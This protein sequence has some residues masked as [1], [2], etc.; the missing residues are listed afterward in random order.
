MKAG[1]GGGPD[2]S[3]NVFVGDDT[4]GADL[5]PALTDARGHF[6]LTNLPPGRYQVIAEAQS[7]QLQGRA[8]NITPD[9]RIAIRLAGVSSLRGNV[10]G[11]H[12]PA[13]LFS[14]QLVGPTSDARSFTDGAFEFPRLD[15]GEY[16]ID[17]TSSDGTGKATARVSSGEPASV[18]IVLVAN[19]T[20]TGRLVDKAGKPLSGKPVAIIPDQLPGQLQIELREQP[21]TSGPDGRFQVEGQPGMR[22]LVILGRR[23]TVKRGVSL[24]AGKT[25]DVGDVTVDE[26]Q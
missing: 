9:A 20:I 25:V 22:T 12:G 19:G 17:V 18:N 5:P 15:P 13:D 11:L 7:G 16:T 4:G 14:V 2:D 23:P 6:A 8:A 24:D 26:K 1:D 10:R 3:R 21:P